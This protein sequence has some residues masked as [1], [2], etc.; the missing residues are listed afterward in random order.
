MATILLVDDEASVVDFLQ[1]ELAF[2]DYDVITAAD[3]QQAYTL[4]QEKKDQLDLVILDWMLPKMDGLEVLRR[5]RKHDTIPV[6]MMTARDYV[7]DKVAGLDG[8]AD[9][10]ITK[11]FDTE[12]LLARIRVVLRH[13]SQANDTQA[14][15]QY[16][17]LEL[18]TKARQVH[19]HQKLVQ[20]TQR[21]YEL[22]LTL[23]QHAEDTLT[24]DEL[25]DQVWG[26]DFEGQPNIVDVYVRYLRHKIDTEANR[27]LIHTVRGVGYCLRDETHV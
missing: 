1:Q 18:D 21:E 19:R 22:L 7:G 13:Q 6:I 23:M 26:V 16:A 15:Y 20:L 25:L 2:E 12:E 5:I 27:K 3:G 14:V 4:Y 24:R 11:P 10:Y 17:D 9:D 8:G